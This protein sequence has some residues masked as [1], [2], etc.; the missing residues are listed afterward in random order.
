VD[1]LTA[2]ARNKLGDEAGAAI[3]EGRESDLRHVLDR[4]LEELTDRT[5]GTAIG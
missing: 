1:G 5:P 3:A 2:R 4:T